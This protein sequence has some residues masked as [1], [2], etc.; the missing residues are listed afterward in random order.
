MN[1]VKFGLEFIILTLDRRLSISVVESMGMFLWHFMAALRPLVARVVLKFHS[2]IN[3]QLKI[4]ALA[5]AVHSLLLIFSSWSKALE[6]VVDNI[7]P[8]KNSMITES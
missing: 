8:A 3:L 1:V 7:K 4:I 6:K 2:I 5:L